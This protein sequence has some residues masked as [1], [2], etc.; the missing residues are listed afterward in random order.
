[1]REPDVTGA[2]SVEVGI[3]RVHGAFRRDELFIFSS[4]SGLLD[5]VQSYSREVDDA[6]NPTEKIAD[7]ESYHRLDALRY[8]GGWLK[9][10]KKK[11]E[12]FA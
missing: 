11:L 12:I 4:L 10:Q 5:E 2:D 3:D 9:R 7:K 1:V 8:V 6:G